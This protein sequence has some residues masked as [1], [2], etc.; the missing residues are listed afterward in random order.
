MIAIQAPSCTQAPTL[1]LVDVDS[2]RLDLARRRELKFTLYHPDLGSL[3]RLLEG[4]GKRQV[5]RRNVSTVRTVYFDDALL[6][7]CH[8][9]LDGLGKRRKLRLR[10]YDSPLPGT[11]CY[12]E[13]KWRD[14]RVTGKH[15]MHLRASEM[16]GN[17]TYKTLWARLATV[18][19]QQHLPTL[20]QFPEPV[21][22]VEYQREHFV[23]IDGHLR[24]TLDY[25]IAYFDQTGKQRISTSFG[26]RHD[27]L[28]VLEGKTPIGY[29]NQLRMF[30]RPFS[31][32][33]TRCSKYTQ[34]CQK[35]GLVRE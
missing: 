21:L 2:H 8:A 15:R 5:F 35:F 14:N 23:S 26:L 31:G 6:S 9:N 13:I 11:E 12:L 22:L 19:P 10:W 24:V 28:V 34:G 18:V 16:V 1:E 17:W 27:G 25:D 29:E 20:F 32:R 7:A 4:N 30:L 33:V 3:R